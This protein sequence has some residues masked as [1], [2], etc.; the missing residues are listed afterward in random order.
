MFSRE[1]DTVC[2]IQACCTILP[3]R[4]SD[5]MAFV[6]MLFLWGE[7][8]EEDP[9]FRRVVLPSGFSFVTVDACR[10]EIRD[11]VGNVRAVI[12]A[13]QDGRKIPSILP[14]KRYSL[15]AETVGVKHRG[16]VYDRGNAVYRSKPLA[17][18]RDAVATA[19]K[20]LDDNKPRWDSY[21]SSVN[22]E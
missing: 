19:R 13:P 11:L 3:A 9:R 15:G 17:A 1:I 20:W 7:A 2:E 6:E 5:H 12:T 14:V 21:I 18:Q 10:F 4:G 16:V 22:F 8:I